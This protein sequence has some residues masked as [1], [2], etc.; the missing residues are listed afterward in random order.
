VCPQI[1]DPKPSV[2]F[3][4]FC[5]VAIFHTTKQPPFLFISLLFHMQCF[6]YGVIA[7]LVHFYKLMLKIVHFSELCKIDLVFLIRRKQQVLFR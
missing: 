2:I 6:L 1:K 3:L 5:R 7:K 4:I